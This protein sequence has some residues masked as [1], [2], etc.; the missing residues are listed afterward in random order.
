MFKFLGHNC[1]SFSVNDTLILT[2]PWFSKKG[3]FFGSWFQ[4]PKNHH[5][6]DECINSIS[7]HSEAFIYISHE[8][9][10]HF[11]LDFLSKIPK[12]TKIIIP[13]YKD[14]TFRNEIKDLQ[15]NIIELDDSIRTK[16]ANEIHLT[17]YV[18]DVGINHDSAILIE[19]KSFNFL[20]QNDCK[21]FDRLNEIKVDIDYYSVQFS[22]ATW[23]PSCFAFS[24]KRKAFLS[25]K[26][27]MN[28]LNNVLNGIKTIK[29]KYYV[30][31]A[32]PAIF[33]FLDINLSLGIDNIFIHHDRLDSFLKENNFYNTVYLK[34]GDT[35]DSK[36]NKPI[37]PP[38]KEEFNEYQNDIEDTWS[39]IKNEFNID[40]LRNEINARINQIKDI[41][42]PELPL[43]I[44]NIKDED[45][46]E[47]IFID[48]NKK[49]I[50]N[51]FTYDSPYEELIADRKYFYLMHSGER[52]QDIYLSLRA[53]VIR[54]PDIFSNLA[55]IFIFSDEENIRD[56]F[57]D[58]TNISTEKISVLDDDGAEYM[59]NRFC[60]HQGADLCNAAIEDGM[61]ICPRHGWKFNL[62]KD[63]INIESGESI[64]AKKI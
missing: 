55:N 47:K 36:L 50:I 19:T 5:L 25:E 7:E 61:L 21:I 16:I 41:N 49:K 59:I 34:P 51:E 6:A 53:T 24:D 2:D 31:A 12:E 4:Y 35:F 28:K 32:G 46:E 43:I 27:V 39:N 54:R 10:D 44:F 40:Y 56:S 8:H 45:Y 57:I 60:P 63:G 9:Q 20:N 26:K 58:S 18:S 64:S 33:P 42:Y 62:K 38:T 37:P 14:K 48:L 17:F 52:W 11:D 1:Y 22:G 23:H 30:P 3:A 29:P 13:S 15:L